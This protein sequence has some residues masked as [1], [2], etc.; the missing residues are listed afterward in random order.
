M[1]L[2]SES[3]LFNNDPL[4]IDELIK[5]NNNNGGKN[6]YTHKSKSKSKKKLYYK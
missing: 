5:W 3:V 4:I 1:H 6:K 2:D